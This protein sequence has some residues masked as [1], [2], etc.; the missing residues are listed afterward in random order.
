M[1]GTMEG[2]VF[3]DNTEGDIHM[4][5]FMFLWFFMRRTYMD[6][7]G[8]HHCDWNDGEFVV[9]RGILPLVLWPLDVP[10][11]FEIGES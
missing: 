7:N 9:S 5:L 2:D 11:C 6:M 8:C 10:S 3:I 1:V 4:F